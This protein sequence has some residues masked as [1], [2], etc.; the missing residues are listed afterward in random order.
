MTTPTQTTALLALLRARGPQGVT[1]LEALGAIGCFRLAARVFDL[2]AEGYEI[3]RK[4]VVTAG[5]HKVVACYILHEQPV[6]MAA[7]G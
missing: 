4:S 3:E 2:R 1:P 7:F 6:Q 5:T